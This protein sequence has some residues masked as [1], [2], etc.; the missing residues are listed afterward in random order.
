ML[1]MN[2]VPYLKSEMWAS[3]RGSVNPTLVAKARQGWG[4]LIGGWRRVKKDGQ[5][6]LKDL[7]DSTLDQDI[8]KTERY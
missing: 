8:L 2:L 7:S 6:A 3:R 5:P 1:R 4:T